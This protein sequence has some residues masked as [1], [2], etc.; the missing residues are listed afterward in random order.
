MNKMRHIKPSK[1][2]NGKNSVKMAPCAAR[3]QNNSYLRPIF[4]PFGRM[5]FASLISFFRVAAKCFPRQ[6]SGGLART[7]WTDTGLGC[8]C[9][10]ALA[11]VL[12]SVALKRLTGSPIWIGMEVIQ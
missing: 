10:D 12:V 1:Q 7:T 6:A 4:K 2:E 5:R 9:W 3:F 8:W 11:V